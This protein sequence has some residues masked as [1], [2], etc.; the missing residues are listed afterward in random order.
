[1]GTGESACSRTGSTSSKG[2]QAQALEE[3]NE[4]CRIRGS[5]EHSPD[6]D[7]RR[8]RQAEGGRGDEARH[9]GRQDDPGYDE[10]PEPDRDLPQDANGELEAA[11]EEDEGNAER[12]DQLRADRVERH[13]D[14]PRHRRPEQEA[15]TEQDEHVREA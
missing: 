8:E 5:G 12:Q 13:V 4:D 15:G 3:R 11:V 7:A 6:Q 1:L 10:H 14:R 9:D 2:P